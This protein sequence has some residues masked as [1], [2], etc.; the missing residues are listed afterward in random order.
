M[1]KTFSKVKNNIIND[2]LTKI[3]LVIGILAVIIFLYK[4][5][6]RENFA[7]TQIYTSADNKRIFDNNYINLYENIIID[8]DKNKYFIDSILNNT[9]ISNNGTILNIG[10]K[11]GNINKLLRE[12]NINSIGLDES[13]D[14]IKFCKNNYRDID[15]HILNYNSLDSITINNNITHILCLNMEIYY[16]ENIDLFFS[17]CYN[18]LDNNGYLIIHIVNYEKYN[19][20]SVYSR[21]HNLNP[22]H[23][24]IKK[25]NDS[26]I[27]FNDI[28][29]NTKYRIYPNDFGNKKVK[30]TETIQNLKNNNIHENI[31]NLNM[32]SNSNLEKIANDHG[33]ILT[34]KIEI[35]LEYYN[36][37]YL[38]IFRKM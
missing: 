24:S 4:S 32:I 21:I 35:N 13:V 3:F 27:Q 19:N 25:V 8:S 37:E 20:T 31:H 11:T 15:F 12:R 17:K 6:K 22:N 10:C 9:N 28:I 36:D 5:N 14:M 34:N 30:F 2:N 33:F 16:I 18:L 1:L 26:M 23:L 29:Y 7:N 38:Y